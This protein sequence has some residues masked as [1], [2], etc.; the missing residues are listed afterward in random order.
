MLEQMLYETGGAIAA[1]AVDDTEVQVRSHPNYF[2]YQGTGG[3]EYVKAA[4]LVGNAD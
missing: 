2:R 1:T 3:W 4:D